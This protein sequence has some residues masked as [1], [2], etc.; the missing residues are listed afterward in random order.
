[1]YTL[2]HIKFFLIGVTLLFVANSLYATNYIVNTKSNLQNRM[3]AALPG[4]TI[5]VTNGIYNNWGVI[6][7]TNSNSTTTSP[8]IVLKAQTIAGVIFT[9][10]TSMQFAGRRVLIYGFKFTNG[11]TGQLDVIQF[12]NAS[13]VPA[14]YCRLSNIIIDNYN[15]DSTGS[16]LNNSS[17]IGN[18]WVSIYGVRNRVDHCTFIN[19]FND[20]A[21]LTIWYDNN[22]YTTPS[23]STYHTIDSN[24]FNGRGYLGD[25]GG[26][27][28]RVGTSSNSRTNG[29]NI[30]EYN[31]FENCIQL[32][33][34]IVS[35]KSNFNIYRYNTFKN[36]NGG[37]TLRHGRY[38]GVYSNFFIVDNP[39]FTRSYG[40]RVID[41]GHKIYNNYFEGLLGNKNSL[42]SL[43]CPI[44]LYNG[45]SSTNDTTDASKASGYF[46]A[47]SCVIAFNTIVN[48]SGGAAMVLGFNDGGANTFQPKGVVIANNLIKMA[49]GQVAFKDATNTS[50]TYL[51]EGNFYNAPSFGLSSSSGFVS[52]TL[53][54]GART[55][56]ILNSPNVVQDAAINTTSYS[57]LLNSLDINGQS[58]SSIFDVGAKELNG[59]GNLMASPLDSTVV[60]AGK[61]LSTLPVRLIS[62]TATT[63]NNEINLKWQVENEINFLEYQIEYSNNG[64][65][66]FNA[67]TVKSEH[68]LL[69]NYVFINADNKTY[70]R[71]KLVDKNGQFTYTNVISVSGNKL[72]KVYPNPAVDAINIYVKNINSN[73]F[74]R[75]VDVTGK[76]VKQVK[77][78]LNYSNIS[79]KELNSGIYQ[80]QLVENNQIINT[81]QVVVLK[82]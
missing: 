55:N 4:D 8:W 35:N 18:K 59:V 31:L 41:K 81:Y 72:I 54:F 65:H 1:M 39:S 11:N 9:G 67:G 58:R 38:C 82:K 45:L 76:C 16:Y 46:P 57:N 34:E 30:I 52:N 20:G 22:T 61:P 51:S 6:N 37:L 53:V 44:I 43:R 78:I 42:T 60:G 40:V 10:N 62:F 24:Y 69:Y 74:L 75:L 70:F 15:S 2:Q 13:N 63:V 27:T 5:V 17:D 32:E 73:S 80:V 19:K 56:G 33:P 23:T 47:D 71:L 64:A 29:F 48:C 49:T 36:C 12:R 21:T 28:I 25:N 7:F 79:T 50:L 26:E 77:N 66:F 14:N 68:K 3:N